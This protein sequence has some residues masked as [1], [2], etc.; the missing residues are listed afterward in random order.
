MIHIQTFRVGTH[1]VAMTVDDNRDI[2][3]ALGFTKRGAE[4]RLL[5]RMSQ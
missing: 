1:C 5:K 3:I 4:R 2:H